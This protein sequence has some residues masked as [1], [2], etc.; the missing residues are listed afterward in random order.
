[1]GSLL[2]PHTA[3]FLEMVSLKDIKKIR[4]PAFTLVE[5]LISIAI[6]GLIAAM[7][8]G[9]F[10]T[11][12]TSAAKTKDLENLKNIGLACAA[13]ANDHNGRYPLKY[14]FAIMPSSQRQWDIVLITGGYL[15]KEV[16]S[17]PADK[18]K[19]TVPGTVRS[20]KYN[21]YLG[22]SKD[23]QPLTVEGN[24]LKISKPLSEIVL[25]ANGG[26]TAS[27]IGANASSAAYAHTNCTFIYGDK[28]AN[29]I[30]LDLHSEWM[31]DSGSFGTTNSAEWYKHWRC[32]LPQ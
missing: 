15:T 10:S 8:F 20:Y 24:I 18:A 13:Y 12:L 5:L 17:S 31:K 9:G 7:L 1:M 19:R 22:D 2:W 16:F 28:G 25:A 6:C 27:V 4:E 21:G 26:G 11:A 14:N 29:Y 32:D 23:E 3:P 30:F